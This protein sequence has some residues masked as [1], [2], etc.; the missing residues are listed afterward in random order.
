MVASLDATSTDDGAIN[1]P[2]FMESLRDSGAGTNG[3]SQGVSV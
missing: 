3:A 2:G 1:H